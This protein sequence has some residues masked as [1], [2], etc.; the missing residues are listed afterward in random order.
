MKI[1]T[2]GNVNSGYVFAPYIVMDL[3]PVVVGNF[4]PKQSMSSRYSQPLISK[5]EKF[6]ERIRNRKKLF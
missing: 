5:K 2:K 4:S 1:G 6:I 3:D